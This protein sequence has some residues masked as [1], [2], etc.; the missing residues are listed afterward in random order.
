MFNSVLLYTNKLKELRRFYMNVLDLDIKT[1][2][3][4]SFSLSI[5][6]SELIFKASEHPHFYHY[7]INIPGNQFSMLK[8]R[9]KE[10]ISLNREGGRD[11]VYFPSF[12]ADSMYFED[13]A[14]NIIELIGRRKNDLF[15]DP[16]FSEAFLN[17]SE[18]G[19]VSP[20]LEEL[21]DDLQDIG[22]P[23]QGARLN[24]ESV[25]FFGRGEAFIIVVPPERK[26]YFSKQI[27]DVFPL[28]ISLTNGY[29]LKVNHEGLMNIGKKDID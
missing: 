10:R 28:E 2:N 4:D 6:S 19:I 7:A 25:N 1:S 23:L 26:W 22:L 18:V 14:G 24:K 11:E 27:S 16:S 17:I 13:P 20:H 15:G 21:S 5:G 12:D 3:E 8:F 9:L 29:H